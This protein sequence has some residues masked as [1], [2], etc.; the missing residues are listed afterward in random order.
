MSNPSE[1]TLFTKVSWPQSKMALKV[2]LLRMLTSPEEGSTLKD[3][4]ESPWSGS[5]QFHDPCHEHVCQ[6]LSS[7]RCSSPASL[8]NPDGPGGVRE[9]QVW[10]MG[11]CSQSRWRPLARTEVAAASAQLGRPLQLNHQCAEPQDPA[12]YPGAFGDGAFFEPFHLLH[13]ADD[14]SW[15]STGTVCRPGCQSMFSR[16]LWVCL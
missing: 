5:A 2:D 15:S 7:C 6:K 9:D 3:L 10:R 4:N 1:Q 12:L 16:V 14:T 11:C 13:L 8:K